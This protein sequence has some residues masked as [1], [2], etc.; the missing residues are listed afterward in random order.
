M[1]ILGIDPGLRITG[2][3]CLEG[4]A[5]GGPPRLVEAGVVRIPTAP[6]L[7]ERLK[8]L[9][10]ELAEVLAEIDPARVAVENLFVHPRNVRTAVLMAHARGVVLLVAQATGRPVIELAP[11]EVKRAATGRG[12]ATKPQVQQAVAGLLG[13]GEPPSPPDVADAL[14]VAL[15][16]FSRADAPVAADA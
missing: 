8:V 15:A 12:N 13:L 11:A 4:T 1:R 14:A 9:H 5:S 2:Y 16:G 6:P 3:A 10:D 7:P